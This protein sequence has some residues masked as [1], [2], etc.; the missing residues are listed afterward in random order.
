MRKYGISLSLFRYVCTF[1]MLYSTPLTSSKYDIPPKVTSRVTF[2][3]PKGSTCL[4]NRWQLLAVKGFT[5][6]FAWSPLAWRLRL[7][8]LVLKPRSFPY[9]MPHGS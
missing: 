9:L 3:K 2:N 6:S 5:L 7:L 8:T 1:S 4:T